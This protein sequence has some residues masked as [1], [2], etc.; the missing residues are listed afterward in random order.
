MYSFTYIPYPCPAPEVYEEHGIAQGIIAAQEKSS[1]NVY[2]FELMPVDADSSE[3]AV[4]DYKKFPVTSEYVL[5]INLENSE[6]TAVA[7]PMKH[8][9][10][11]IAEN[12]PKQEI[13]RKYYAAESQPHFSNLTKCLVEYILNCKELFNLT[14]QESSYGLVEWNIPD[15]LKRDLKITK[16]NFEEK[17]TQ[18]FI[19]GDS[20]TC[21]YPPNEFPL[22]E[23]DYRLPTEYGYSVEVRGE[24][25]GVVMWSAYHPPHFWSSGVSPALTQGSPIS[26]IPQLRDIETAL[27]SYI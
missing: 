6:F 20:L 7:N 14:P 15:I 4:V 16:D 25:S 8:S 9:E 5:N 22:D 17:L 26:E 1:L 2:L 19:T 3:F 27:K 18:W 24:I 11:V 21:I 12:L 13:Y 23:T 10:M